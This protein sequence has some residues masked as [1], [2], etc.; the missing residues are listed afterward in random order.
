MNARR[1][2]SGDKTLLPFEEQEGTIDQ[3]L[4]SQPTKELEMFK[5]M[6]A[7]TLI[8]MKDPN[9]FIQIFK[10]KLALKSGKELQGRNIK[11]I[12]QI[13]KEKPLF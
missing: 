6:L 8:T 13:L 3:L 5:K 2:K 10:R 1:R 11:I 12:E 9:Q 4:D 7:E